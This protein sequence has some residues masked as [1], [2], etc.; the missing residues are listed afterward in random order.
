M[1][2]NQFAINPDLD[3]IFDTQFNNLRQRI[4]VIIDRFQAY[5]D[6]P[7]Q[8]LSSIIMKDIELATAEIYSLRSIITSYYAG[9]LRSQKIASLDSKL[10]D[11][12]AI[13]ESVRIAKRRGK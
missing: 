3:K 1:N 12:K 8:Q 9:E 2:N 4:Q 13:Y 5:S 10:V 7:N 11:L 6:N